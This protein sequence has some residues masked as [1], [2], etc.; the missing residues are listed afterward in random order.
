[1]E[2]TL[3]TLLK[4]ARTGAG[5]TQAELAKRVGLTSGELSKAE[6]GLQSLP[7]DILKKIGRETG[8][9]QKALVQ[10]AKKL[11]N[12]GEEELTAG[13]KTLIK[14]YRKADPD[15]RK[16]AVKILKGEKTDVE[17]L[18]SSLLGEERYQKFLKKTKNK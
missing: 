17:L 2:E 1:M 15:A 10:A 16:D 4:K 8:A 11:P 6:R 18:V 12:A 13:E 3:G 7:E 5:L 9:S 14:L